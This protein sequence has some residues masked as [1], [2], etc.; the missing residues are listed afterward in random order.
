LRHHY[1]RQ[2]SEQLHVGQQPRVIVQQEL[3]KAR[4]NL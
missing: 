3:L 1:L 2:V 4:G